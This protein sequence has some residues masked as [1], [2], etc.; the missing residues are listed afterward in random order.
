MKRCR[1]KLHVF[2]TYPY[3]ATTLYPQLSKAQ[4]HELE[5]IYKEAG[6]APIGPRRR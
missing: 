4:Q 3:L 5:M 6:F 2:R 1:E